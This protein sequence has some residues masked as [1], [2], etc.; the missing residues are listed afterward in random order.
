MWVSL[1][2]IQLGERIQGHEEKCHN[3]NRISNFEK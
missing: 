2:G 1:E 3:K